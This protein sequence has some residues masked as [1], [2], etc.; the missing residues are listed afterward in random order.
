MNEG[1]T[2]LVQLPAASSLALERVAAVGLALRAEAE[3][4]AVV[5]DAGDLGIEW[6]ARREPMV[7]CHSQRSRRAHCSLGCH[8]VQP[9]P[10]PLPH[11]DSGPC[12][13]S[14]PMFLPKPD[15]GAE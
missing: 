4:T 12:E 5:A 11:T 8:G 15:P 6:A 14:V 9:P 3:F 1:V 2:P 10:A 13:S 7:R